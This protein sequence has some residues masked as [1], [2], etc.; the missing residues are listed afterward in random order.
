MIKNASLAKWRA[1]ER[2][3]G[4]WINLSDVH[5]VESL[6]R[7]DFD[8]ICLDLQHGLL[9]YSHILSLIPALSATDTTPLVRVSQNDAGEIGRAL[10]AGAQGVIVPMVN[11]AEEAAAAAMACRYPP[12]GNRSCGPMRGILYNG[13][14]Y[15]AGANGETA[16][17]A[18]IETRAGLANAGAIART[19]GIDALFVGPFDLCFGLGITPGDFA[20]PAYVSALETIKAACREAG[21]AAGI[22]GYSAALARDALDSGFQFA[23]IG[24]DIGFAREGAR[25]ALKTVLNNANNPASPSAGY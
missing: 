5:M 19:P 17:I 6:A 23:S 16:C 13:P 3:V 21:C 9:S 18:M 2:S 25:V 15:L 1:N 4:A 7:M 20:N 8:W 14:D 12:D 11:T 22:F 10:D 24:T